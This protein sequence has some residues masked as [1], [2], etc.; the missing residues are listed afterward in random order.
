MISLLPHEHETSELASP[1][2]DVMDARP[3]PTEPVSVI[4]PE[5]S[6]SRDDDAPHGA[7]LFALGRKGELKWCTPGAQRDLKHLSARSG[8][9][10]GQLIESWTR[11]L[12][13]LVNVHRL[14]FQSVSLPSGKWPCGGRVAWSPT[15]PMEL[16]VSIWRLCCSVSDADPTW[17]RLIDELRGSGPT[18]G[19][20]PA[21]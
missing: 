19:G 20:R 3:V 2:I 17:R 21:A 9:K 11:D 4:L 13:Q 6:E 15:R 14:D 1:F 8:R 5:H 12:W 10:S 7:S 18:G 16:T